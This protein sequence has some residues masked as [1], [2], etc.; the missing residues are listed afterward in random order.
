MKVDGRKPVSATASRTAGGRFAVE[1]T[2]SPCVPMM[3]SATRTAVSS[4]LGA[5][6]GEA[7]AGLRRHERRKGGPEALWQ[8]GTGNVRV[9]S[10]AAIVVA[11]SDFGSLNRLRSSKNPWS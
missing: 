4:E 6:I 10:E 9:G 7:R 8:W 2:P 5:Q 1:M 3:A 11:T